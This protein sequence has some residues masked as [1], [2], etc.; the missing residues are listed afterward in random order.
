MR[1]LP[2]WHSFAK[3]QGWMDELSAEMGSRYTNKTKSQGLT[4][5]CFKMFFPTT[6]YFYYF[7]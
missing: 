2:S 7:E 6:L 3:V 5:D 4:P 1:S